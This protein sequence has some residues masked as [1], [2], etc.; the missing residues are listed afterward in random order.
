MVRIDLVV[1]DPRNDDLYVLYGYNYDYRIDHLE[2]GR[3]V[4]V[5]EGPHGY[6]DPITKIY[7]TVKL[8][9]RQLIFI[10]DSEDP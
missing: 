4:I 7:G 8:M 3:I 5:K 1:Y 9:N 6:N 2:K 10:A